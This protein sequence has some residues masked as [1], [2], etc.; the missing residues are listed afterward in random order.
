MRGDTSQPLHPTDLG[1]F[2]PRPAF[3]CG[4]TSPSHV[5]LSPFCVSI[6][7]PHS[8][9][10]RHQVLAGD[11]SVEPFQSAPRIRM[12]G[13]LAGGPVFDQLVCFNPRPAFE[14]GATRQKFRQPIRLSMFQSAPRI[15]MRGDD[16]CKE[17]NYALD[18]FNPRPAFECGATR[19]PLIS[20]TKP[21]SFNPRPAF[22]CGATQGRP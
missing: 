19:E 8:N 9:A 1:C 22:E 10:G 21:V 2:N 12:R 18:R 11:L 17:K 20:A 7:A 16:G 5:G 3:E 4:A 14:C 13:D 6:R 15:R